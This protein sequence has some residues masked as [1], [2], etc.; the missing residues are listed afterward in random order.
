MP[1][2][3]TVTDLVEAAARGEQEAWDSLVEQFM[4]L[5]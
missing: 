3:L 5:V 2:N 1:E 4:P